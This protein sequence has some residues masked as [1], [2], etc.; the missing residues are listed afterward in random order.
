MIPSFKNVLY[1]SIAL[2]VALILYS[3]WHDARSIV[4]YTDVDY[5]V[6]TDAARFILQPSAANRARGP[7]LN[8]LALGDPYARDTYRY[9]PLLAL[10]LTPNI[11]L[12]PSFG[13]YVFAACDILNGLII[14][15]VLVN[16]IL[17]T[18]PEQEKTDST[19]I[20]K[21]KTQATL[22][23]AIHLLNPMVFSI[24]TRGSSESLL[25]AFVLLTLHALLNDRWTIAAIFLGLS[26]HWKIYPVIYG[27]SSVCLIGS[28]S[29]HSKHKSGGLTGWLKMVVNLRTVS[30]A[31]VSAGTFLLLGGFCY[32]IWGYPFL[33]ESYLYHLHRLD[34][35][36]NFSPYF[37]PTYLSYPSLDTQSAP[38]TASPSAWNTMLES[39]LTSF[40][41]Q[42]ILSL[43]T[44]LLSSYTKADLPFSWFV[45]TCCFVIFNKVCTSQ[46]FLW[47]LLFL[48]FLLPNL[49]MSRV[50]AFACIGVWIGVQASWLSEAYK[51]EF[52]GQDVFL[53]LWYRSLV[54]VIGNCWVLVTMMLSYKAVVE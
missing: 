47:Y 18:D 21:M 2:R 44:G 53:S 42:L 8:Q 40:F 39:P 35:R 5:R 7:I 27:V 12:H 46:Y 32:A 3:E 26:T 19:L 25:L 10:I 4:K 45:Q 38:P 37:Y 6:F 9:T 54:Y 17:T 13:K 22:Y 33:Y 11:F 51:L 50:K 23:T 48:P 16:H 49:R 15:N 31:L 43:G 29:S 14:Y 36:H 1:A 41:P 34:H 52:L 28:L 30:F 24:S 20:A